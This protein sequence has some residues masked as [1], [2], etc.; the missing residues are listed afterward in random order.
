MKDRKRRVAPSAIG[1]DVGDRTCQVC[2]LGA[3]GAVCETRSVPT[4]RAALEGRLKTYPTTRVAIEAGTHSAWIYE[5]VTALGHEVIVANPR[6]VRLIS[7][8][9][10][11]NDR[12]DAEILA[13]LARSDPK[14][15]SPVIPKSKSCRSARIQLK[16]RDTVVAN[17]T[18]LI[19]SVRCV[20]K[21]EGE[22]VP[23]C[24]AEAFPR[25]AR[26]ALPRDVLEGAEW[27]LEEIE[28]LTARIGL[29]DKTIAR[30]A[31]KE[32]PVTKLLQTIPGV[33]PITSLAY[34]TGVGDPK[35]FSSSR[36]V[37]AYFGLQPRQD[38]SG[39]S[40]P[41]LRITKAGDGLVRKLLVQAAHC[42]L[43]RGAECD[44]KRWGQALAARGRKNAK[45]RAV[46]AVA[47]KLAVVMHCMWTSGE[48]FRCSEE[49]R[50]S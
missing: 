50:K 4:T 24:S 3:D 6:K 12:A 22:R 32:F 11:K 37:G 28:T 7:E 19:N 49:P 29:L 25:V 2:V 27:A 1:I 17:R 18:A 39:Q 43:H 15:L 46:I 5:S 41:E 14:L 36:T 33:G 30:I 8:S 31:A 45:K 10:R 44:L 47:R 38:E 9:V 34:V 23:K 20:V 13:R 16:L 35:R 42:L 21:G 40:A 26:G 48:E